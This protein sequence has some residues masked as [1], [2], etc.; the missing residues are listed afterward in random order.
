VEGEVT[1]VATLPPLM[2]IPDGGGCERPTNDSSRMGPSRSHSCAFFRTFMLKDR[3]P[4]RIGRKTP[5][6]TKGGE[7]N[8]NSVGEI[9]G[10]LDRID[11][12]DPAV[13]LDSI[14]SYA[15]HHDEIVTALIDEACQHATEAN[16]RSPHRT[17]R[18]TSKPLGIGSPGVHK[19]LKRARSDMTGGV[20]DRK[21]LQTATPPRRKFSSMNSKMISNDPSDFFHQDCILQKEMESD[22]QM[23]KLGFGLPNSRSKSNDGVP[24]ATGREDTLLKLQKKLSLLGDIES[25]KY[26]MAAE[27]LR[28]DAVAFAKQVDSNDF[29]KKKRANGSKVE[30]RSILTLRMGFVSMSYGILLQWDCGTG[31]VELIVLRKMCRD[32]FLKG[33]GD[34]DQSAR[35]SNH[36]I[37]GSQR[38]LQTKMPLVPPKPALIPAPLADVSPTEVSLDSISPSDFLQNASLPTNPLV[39]ILSGASTSKSEYLLSVSVLRVTGLFSECD[40]CRNSNSVERTVRGRTVRPFIR[41]SLGKH[42]HCTSVTVL[43]NGNAKWS[44]RHHN[45]CLLPCPPEGLRWFAGREDLIVEVHNDWV[46]PRSSGKVGISSLRQQMFGVNSGERTSPHK[47][48]PIL[49]AVKVPLSSVNIEDDDDISDGGGT[50]KHIFK[51]SASS[52]KITMPLRMHCCSNAPMGSISL[53][54]TMKVPPQGGGANTSLKPPI[55][56]KPNIQFVNENIE[57]GPLTRILDGWSLGGGVRE[58]KDAAKSKSWK[59]RN[60]LRWSKRFDLHTRR[61]SNLSPTSTSSSPKKKGNQ[62][63]GAYGWFT[64]LNTK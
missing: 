36:L 23:P 29:T 17:K 58:T 26:G 21:H 3:T 48:R 28:S 25:G 56:A 40:N 47:D 18:N 33:K 52:T 60:R 20:V 37:S 1:V 31:L 55:P 62:G 59:K 51:D 9:C 15:I 50:R 42:D 11:S 16:S 43:N 30:T 14:E 13:P 39:S 32:D 41:F 22:I 6:N 35:E 7:D 8:N 63:E 64:F 61:W 34:G 38:N 49:A 53:K 10:I 19:L 46:N 57:L 2:P 54:I 5:A 27:M 44:H 12:D 24:S 4:P 45:S